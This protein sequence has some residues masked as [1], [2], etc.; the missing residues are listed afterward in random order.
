MEWTVEPGTGPG[1]G[2]RADVHLDPGAAPVTVE[3]LH[4]RVAALQLWR[5][6][7]SALLGRGICGAERRS[8]ASPAPRVAGPSRR[9]SR[10]SR[11]FSTPRCAS[12]TVMPASA[13]SRRSTRRSD[14][15]ALP[16][17]TSCAR[18]HAIGGRQS[19][20]TSGWI[21]RSPVCERRS[22]SRLCAKKG[23]R[24]PVGRTVRTNHR[25]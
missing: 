25:L 22:Y 20:A 13:A 3:H 21:H 14:R 7:A 23:R 15:R 4:D 11:P 6:G 12:R 10:C 17:S 1:S 19:K 18:G 8:I 24:W 16:R 2:G 9:S 5:R